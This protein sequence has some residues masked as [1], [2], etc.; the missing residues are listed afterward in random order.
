MSDLAGRDFLD[1]RQTE[2]LLEI[3]QA[4]CRVLRE[5]PEG[6]AASIA[7]RKIIDAFSGETFDAVEICRRAGPPVPALLGAD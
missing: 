7:A 6:H 3:Y 2:L 4:S 5:L 1:P